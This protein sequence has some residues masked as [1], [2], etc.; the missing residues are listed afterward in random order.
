M[1]NYFLLLM[2]H[3]TVHSH[4]SN[5][6]AFVICLLNIIVVVIDVALFLIISEKWHSH[7]QE[8]TLC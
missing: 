3:F 8:A 5:S 2:I 1:S 6:P 4:F 7:T